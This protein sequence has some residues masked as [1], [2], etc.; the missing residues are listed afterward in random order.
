[1]L[2]TYQYEIN[3]DV[4]CVSVVLIKKITANIANKPRRIS[5]NVR[6]KKKKP[7]NLNS[8]QITLTSC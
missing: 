5:A 2:E 6:E 7:N 3:Y 4:K 8:V 1:M